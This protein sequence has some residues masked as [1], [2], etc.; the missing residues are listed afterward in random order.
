MRV[1]VF[2]RYAFWQDF[3]QLKRMGRWSYRAIEPLRFDRLPYLVEIAKLRSALSELTL[4]QEARRLSHRARAIADA[5]SC[6]L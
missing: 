2:D 3:R 6:A 4:A 1:R 5:K